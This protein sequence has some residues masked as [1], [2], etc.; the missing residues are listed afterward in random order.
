MPKVSI[1]MPAYNVEKYIRE[2]MDSVIAQTL[3]DIEIIVVDDGST[4]TTGAILDSYAEADKRVRVIHKENSGYG[5]S[6]NIGLKEA[7]GEY[8]GIVET[9]DF[10][11]SS[12][13]ELLYDNAKHFDADVVK[14]LYFDYYSEKE[15]HDKVA[16]KLG[17]VHAF[18]EPFRP[19]DH[20]RVFKIP[21]SIWSGI[22]RRSMVEDNEI[23][24]LETPGASYQDTAF[25]FKIWACAEKVVFIN[26]PL[27]H[28][29]QDN[30]GSS[31]NNNDKKPFCV[32]DEF[33]EIERFLNEDPALKERFERIMNTAKF[34]VYMWNYKRLGPVY[35]YSFLEKMKEELLEADKASKLDRDCLS[36]R[37]YAILDDLL[38]NYS[39]EEYYEMTKNDRQNG[40]RGLRSRIKRWIR[41]HVR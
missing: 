6:M 32:C 28:Y 41:K 3:E 25:A 4:D 13:F 17:D 20:P 29:R 39:T 5:A 1:I 33:T 38:Y 11:E 27:L 19:E 16:D 30:L 10:A 2:C 37:Q 26:E 23:R 18:Y 24:F 7:K 9:D 12:M 8:I 36:E 21:P 35:K 14:C 15:P 31:V 40:K 22:Y 34:G